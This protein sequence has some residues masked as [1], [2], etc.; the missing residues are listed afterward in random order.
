MKPVAKITP[1]EIGIIR[2]IQDRQFR[3]RCHGGLGIYRM[4]IRY[5]IDN[6]IFG[7]SSCSVQSDEIIVGGT[8]T[9]KPVHMIGNIYFR[10]FTAAVFA[11]VIP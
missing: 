4:R 10:I 8:Q 3:L 9:L 6:R 5:F 2:T 1:A 7:I 11:P